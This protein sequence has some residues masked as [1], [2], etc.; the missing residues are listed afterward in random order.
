MPEATRGLFPVLLRHAFP[1][2]AAA[3]FLMP[4][5]WVVVLSL[6]PPGQG[7]PVSIEWWPRDPHWSNY[8]RIFDL[9]PLARQAWN[10]FLVAAAAVPL[11]VLSASCAGYAISAA[12]RK[13]RRRMVLGA[14]VLML[15]PA[16]ALWLTRFVLFK[17]LGLMDSLW[18]LIV[19]ALGGT[20]PFYIL[21]F[22][23]TFRRIPG[24]IFE[25]A[26]LEGAG[27]WRIW[28]R[29][30]MPLA[31][32]TVVTVSVLAFTFYWSDV[33]S[34]LLYLKSSSR[35]TLP[36]GLQALES[37]DFTDRPL[38]MAGA[39]LSLLPIVLLFLVAHRFFWPDELLLRPVDLRKN[40]DPG[41][42]E[43]RQSQ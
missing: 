23:W 4:L 5:W 37:M 24:E 32:P 30:A 29:I 19:P 7:V 25:S 34:P 12:S 22:Y 17:N 26:R 27:H 33:I 35:Y 11:T 20:N 13:V 41:V 1:A 8:S 3:A 15:V 40:G 16:T 10:S 28:A 39:V 43:A 36:V 14:V 2:A 21:L 9:V 38:V 18:A 31:R 6:R 42:P